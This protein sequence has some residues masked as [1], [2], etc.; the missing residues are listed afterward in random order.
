M[1]EGMGET[2][3]IYGTKPKKLLKRQ[4]DWE[5]QEWAK[6]WEK[7]LRFMALNQ[8]RHD[9]TCWMMMINPETQWWMLGM[10]LHGRGNV[11]QHDL[12]R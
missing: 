11:V 6:E 2:F 8:K 12:C 10:E 7:H 1:G 9:V 5:S 4:R 3:E